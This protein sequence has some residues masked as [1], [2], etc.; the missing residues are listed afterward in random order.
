MN[1]ITSS[2]ARAGLGPPE[3]IVIAILLL[4]ISAAIFEQSDGD[5][6]YR[7]PVLTVRDKRVLIAGLAL[8]SLL[9]GFLIW[10]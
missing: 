2:A 7:G 8:L 3:W 4:L 1:W 9:G 6:D 10:R 5:R